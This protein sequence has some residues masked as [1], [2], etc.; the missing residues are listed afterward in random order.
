LP[1][2]L[3]WRQLLQARPLEAREREHALQQHCAASLS[4]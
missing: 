2:A 4:A 1:I 3:A